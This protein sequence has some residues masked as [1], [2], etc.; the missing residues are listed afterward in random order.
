MLKPALQI[1]GDWIATRPIAP[2]HEGEAA[3]VI[4]RKND[5]VGDDEGVLAKERVRDRAQRLGRHQ[6]RQL[7]R[8][9]HLQPLQRLHIM[10]P[11]CNN[12]GVSQFSGVLIRA[13]NS[14][15]HGS[16][17]ACQVSASSHT[18]YAPLNCWTLPS[19]EGD[20]VF[21][22]KIPKFHLQSQRGVPKCNGA[23]GF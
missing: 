18:R 8:R 11:A 14:D 10:Q 4:G 13:P 12:F 2:D 15:M 17:Q 21:V 23:F 20:G 7:R 22:V 3:G 19:G 1:V 9:Q 16:H 5:G 6:P